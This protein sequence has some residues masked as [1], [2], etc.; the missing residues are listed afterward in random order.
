M[1]SKMFREHLFVFM[2]ASVDVY[3]GDRMKLFVMAGALHFM[4]R[5]AENDADKLELEDCTQQMELY[6]RD[7]APK[8][9]K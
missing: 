7:Y 3:C 9:I 1:L 8:K 2:Q 5:D 4:R 6:E